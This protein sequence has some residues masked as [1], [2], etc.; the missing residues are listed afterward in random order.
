[1]FENVVKGYQMVNNKSR[2]KLIESLLGNENFFRFEF[3]F[4]DEGRVSSGIAKLQEDYTKLSTEI[5]F[6][7]RTSKPSDETDARLNFLW[8]RQLEILETMAFQSSQ[9]LEKISACLNL[10]KG[11][12]LDFSIC[13]EGLREYQIGNVD[14]AQR[15]F[16]K[17]LSTHGD[18]ANH[19]QLNKIYGRI[20]FDAGDLA[21]SKIYL[22][23]VTQI[24]PEDSEVHHWLEEI[25]SRLNDSDAAQVNHEIF[26]LLEE[27]T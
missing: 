10:L 1:M 12:N 5:D 9:R 22:Q 25:Y 15:H 2:L 19:Y 26:K 4:Y 7:R 3:S 20:K 16:E 27:Q 18:F 8:Q 6:V 11:L 21:T 13:L 17:Y 14:T 23:R 24:C